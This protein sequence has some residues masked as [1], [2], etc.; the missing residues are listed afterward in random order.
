MKYRLWIGDINGGV[1]VDQDATNWLHA[2]R[3]R[4][5]DDVRIEPA[6]AETPVTF[7]V[8]DGTEEDES[9]S[10]TFLLVQCPRCRANEAIPG[11]T[12]MFIVTCKVCGEPFEPHLPLV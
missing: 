3:E 11:A 12:K 10:T 6:S 4:G 7:P 2:M 8:G 9:P 5:Y 1:A